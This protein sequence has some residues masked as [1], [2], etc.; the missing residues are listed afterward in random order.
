[1]KTVLS[2]AQIQIQ[3]EKKIQKQLEQN[4]NNKEQELAHYR[5]QIG[6]Q[7]EKLSQS[8]HGKAL[9]HSRLES[10][11]LLFH[12]E[13]PMPQDVQDA[14]LSENEESVISLFPLFHFHALKKCALNNWRKGS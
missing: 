2:Q 10:I 9:H 13:I 5:Q 4:L 1:M 7:A 8:I 3:E 14:I 11:L 12:G 6:L